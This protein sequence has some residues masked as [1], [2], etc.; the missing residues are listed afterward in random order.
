MKMRRTRIIDGKLVTTNSA[1]LREGCA[2]SHDSS[3]VVGV[4]AYNVDEALRGKLSGEVLKR[5][6]ELAEKGAE[7]TFCTTW[8][9]KD[10]DNED[11]LEIFSKFGIIGSSFSNYVNYFIAAENFIGSISISA[12]CGF[13]E[14]TFKTCC[15]FADRLAIKRALDKAVKPYLADVQGQIVAN[16]AWYYSEGGRLGKQSTN[17]TI[18]ETLV[19]DAYPA[20]GRID[21]FVDEY[22]KSTSPVLLLVGKHGMGKSRLIR[23]IIMQHGLRTKKS[24]QVIYTMDPQVYRGHDSFFMDFRSDNFDF[25]IIEDADVMLCSRKD[26]NEIMHKFLSAADGLLSNRDKKIIITTNLSVSNIDDALVRPGRCFALVNTGLL[27]RTQAVTLAKKIGVD[28]GI[29]PDGTEMTVSDVYNAKTQQAVRHLCNNAV[30]PVAGFR[31]AEAI[32]AGA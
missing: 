17:E 6:E 8:L 1:L 28:P 26:G 9:L 4:D 25:L 5:A 13:K 11:I 15:R 23:Y 31:K 29:L 2:K 32:S 30:L 19:D 10:M 7:Y 12:T 3:Y 16:V 21:Q 22:I 14:A 18:L 27:S 24:P 20:I